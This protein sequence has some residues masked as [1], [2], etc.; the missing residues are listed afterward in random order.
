MG[1]LAFIHLSINQPKPLPDEN[2]GL[3][4]G[5]SKASVNTQF[6]GNRAVLAGF[7]FALLHSP[8]Q[9]WGKLFSKATFA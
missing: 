1:S 8:Q 5:N 4:I 3:A 6:L 2:E 9:R 7:T